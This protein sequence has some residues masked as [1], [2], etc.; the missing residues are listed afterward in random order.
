MPA[1][2]RSPGSTLHL[3]E[4]VFRLARDERWHELV[5]LV[6]PSSRLA[7]TR[8]DHGDRELD[9]ELRAALASS[10]GVQPGTV[11][12]AIEI[13]EPGV[14]IVGDTL[15]EQ[16]PRGHALRQVWWVLVLQDDRLFAYH[17][18]GTR[19]QA[20]ALAGRR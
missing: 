1:P 12:D 16:L 13:V 10:R 6:H 14:A 7:G 18:A 4:Q 15:R 2:D 19:G 11:L 8:F 17:I 5:E 3:V 9:P 20:A